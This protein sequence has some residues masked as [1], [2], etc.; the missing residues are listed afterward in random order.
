MDN[1]LAQLSGLQSLGKWGGLGR[2]R[3]AMVLGRFIEFIAKRVGISLFGETGLWSCRLGNA[4][5]LVTDGAW[6]MELGRDASAWVQM[7]DGGCEVVGQAELCYA[8]SAT[9]VEIHAGLLALLWA[10]A[11]GIRDICI[12]TDCSVFVQ[13]LCDPQSAD[14]GLQAV[15]FYFFSMCSFF[16]SVNPL[17]LALKRIG[18]VWNQIS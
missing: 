17:L 6:K 12:R 11:Q 18:N 3:L 10:R 14:V 1:A 9:M 4:E 13:G 15:L 5:V 16:N 8:A 2:C 7:D